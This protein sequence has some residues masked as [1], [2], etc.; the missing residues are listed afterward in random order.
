MAFHIPFEHR[1]CGQPVYIGFNTPPRRPRFNWW[2]F[3]GFPFSILSL[4][5]VGILSPIALVMNL[6]A[7][8]KGPR[9][10]ATAGTVISLVGV[11]LLTTVALVASSAGVRAHRQRQ[12]AEWNREVQKQTVRTEGMLDQV[13]GEFEDWRNKNSGE[14]PGWVD[15]NMVAL[16]YQDPWGQGLRFD[17]EGDHAILRSAGPDSQFDT[18]DDVT[19]RIEGKAEKQ[20]SPGI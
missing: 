15:A 20:V 11:G 14:L 16:G 1:R 18:G 10:L 8:R 12:A 6:I 17:A 4:F 5:T 9:R 19:R 3:F 13:A 7:L 2:A